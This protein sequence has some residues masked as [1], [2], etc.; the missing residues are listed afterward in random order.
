MVDAF[1]LVCTECAD[2]FWLDA[3]RGQKSTVYVDDVILAI[4]PER[5]EQMFCHG[6]VADRVSAVLADGL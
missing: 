4:L 3:R 6:P 1:S 5:S 2:V